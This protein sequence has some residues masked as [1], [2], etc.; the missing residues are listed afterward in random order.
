MLTLN[1]PVGFTDM[2]HQGL[3]LEG[4][5]YESPMAALYNY[6]YYIEHFDAYGLEKEADWI[7]IRCMV[8]ETAPEKMARVGSM[9]L[10]RYNVKI[11]PVKNSKELLKRYGYSFF[12][13]I[14]EAYKPLYNYSP[15]TQRQKEYYSKMYF[16][17]LNFDFVTLVANEQDELVAVGVCMPNL[18]PALRKAK[19][20]LFPFGWYHL[21]KALKGKT[22]DALD[23]LLIAVR[24]DYQN[25]GLNSLLFI[26]Q[27]PRYH[28]YKIKEARV[29]AVLETNTKNQA[30]FQYM[31]HEFYK[32]RRAYIKN[33]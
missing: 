33:L 13:V 14:D 2:D 19:G 7:E 15:L 16:P 20:K 27:I 5:E 11:V 22:M 31:E 26:D 8:P 17:L 1:G 23:L 6:P 3:L 28:Q 32:R 24:P 21:L 18:T 10:N 30:N 9:I 4:F 25:K 29:T 12:D